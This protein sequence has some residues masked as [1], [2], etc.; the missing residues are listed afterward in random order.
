[1]RFIW[2]PDKEAKNKTKHGLDSSFAEVV[3]ADPLHAIVFDRTEDGEE[4]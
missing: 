3:F 4:R 1:V 2:D